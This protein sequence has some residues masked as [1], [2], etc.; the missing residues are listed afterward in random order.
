MPPGMEAKHP[1]SVVNPEFHQ[2][3]EALK[4]KLFGVKEEAS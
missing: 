2:W 1:E 3:A 4:Q